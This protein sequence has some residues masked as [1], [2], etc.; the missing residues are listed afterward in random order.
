MASNTADFTASVRIW[1]SSLL[2]KE[3]EIDMITLINI[4][5][6]N[7]IIMNLIIMNITIMNITIMNRGAPEFNSGWNSGR[8][9]GIF[10]IRPDLQGH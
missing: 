4:M 6:I 10:K 2:P 8:I 3:N 9:W 1:L 5:V 7:M